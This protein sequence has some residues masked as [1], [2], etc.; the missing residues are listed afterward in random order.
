MRNSE[1]VNFFDTG[2]EGV[3]AGFGEHMLKGVGVGEFR[4]SDVLDTTVM[5]LNLLTGVG[6]VLF[7]SFQ[8][9]LLHT[10]CLL[11]FG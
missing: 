9:V 5:G 3:R 2:I 8:Y 6:I 4:A 1:P 7:L 11:S 10:L